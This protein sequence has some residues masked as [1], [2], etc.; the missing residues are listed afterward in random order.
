MADHSVYKVKGKR[1]VHDMQITKAQVEEIETAFNLFIDDKSMSVKPVDMVR[2]FE[3][4]GL[5]Q[6]KASIYAMIK[7]MDNAYNNE[8]GITFDEFMSNAC[9][10]FN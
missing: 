8:L 6:S 7:S 3:K 4:I 10:Y 2:C 1:G 9:D 5:D